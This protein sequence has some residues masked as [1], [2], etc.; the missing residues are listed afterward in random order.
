MSFSLECL[1]NVHVVYTLF[2]CPSP[3]SLPGF[4]WYIREYLSCENIFGLQKPLFWLP[5]QH[6][7]CHGNE[8][9]V[10]FLWP[11]PTTL[12]GFDWYIRNIWAVRN[13]FGH[14]GNGCQGNLVF[15]IFQTFRSKGPSSCQV[16]WK[17]GRKAICK[18]VS[19]IGALETLELYDDC[20]QPSCFTSHFIIRPGHPQYNLWSTSP[21][22]SSN[23]SRQEKKLTFKHFFPP[24]F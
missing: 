4:D 14:P 23:S 18:N 15:G 22:M 3:T 1:L 20:P 16:S 19:Y 9:F 8:Y 5:W 6:I 11:S 7:G 12:P 24:I 10:H 21:L 13:L 17:S 2:L